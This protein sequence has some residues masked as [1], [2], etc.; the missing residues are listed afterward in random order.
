MI[1]CQAGKGRN[2]FLV[3]VVCDHQGEMNFAP[4]EPPVNRDAHSLVCNVMGIRPAANILNSECHA[5]YIQADCSSCNA[6][7]VHARARQNCFD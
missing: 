4:G 3:C 1:C 5:V 6:L 7:T 2:L